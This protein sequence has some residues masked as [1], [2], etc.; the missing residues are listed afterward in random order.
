[1]TIARRFFLYLFVV[2]LFLVS[3]V[4]TE[5][6]AQDTVPITVTRVQPTFTPA[7]TTVPITVTRVQPTPT[8]ALAGSTEDMTIIQAM[9]ADG[10]FSI[11]LSLLETAGMTSL[12]NGEGPFTVFAPSDAAFAE[13][14]PGA[15]E[16]LRT[17]PELSDFLARHIVRELVTTSAIATASVDCDDLRATKTVEGTELIYGKNEDAETVIRGHYLQTGEIPISL[18][19]IP[20][21]N[22]FIYVTEAPILPLDSPLRYRTIREQ[23]FGSNLDAARMLEAIYEVGG[24]Y[25]GWPCPET[26]RLLKQLDG[27]QPYTLFLPAD[28]ALVS[29]ENAFDVR[30]V[31]VVTLNDLA[32]YHIAE[33]ALLLPELQNERSVQTLLG[34]PITVSQIAPDRLSMNGLEVT[35]LEERTAKNGVIY[36]ID[37]L[38]VPPGMDLAHWPPTIA[39]AIETEPGFQ[40]LWSIWGT[41]E[42]YFR[43]YFDTWGPFTVFVTPDTALTSLSEAQLEALYPPAN[44]PLYD[45][46]PAN[47]HTLF[48]EVEGII[49]PSQRRQ[50]RMFS[51]D[52]FLVAVNDGVMTIGNEELGYAT[53]VRTIQASNGVIYVLDRPLLPPP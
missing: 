49:D 26:P 22:G 35:I 23:L 52:L 9:A 30:L 3:C 4:P 16:Q 45:S 37:K 42:G 27:D 28:S 34:Q 25:G 12:L 51:R 19:I 33:E 24:P 29:A 17:D 47:W 43:D 18:W 41:E 6:A 38:L 1:M 50:I 46:R 11:F 32:L 48:Y 7:P 36:L 5:P 40:T 31:D 39:E 21:A 44:Y 15:V 14:Q 20:A 10:R 2:F 8:S 13:L 53:I